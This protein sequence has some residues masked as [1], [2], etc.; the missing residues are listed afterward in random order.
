MNAK[1]GGAYPIEGFDWLMG[2]DP[3]FETARRKLAGIVWDSKRGALPLRYREIVA[4][5]VL[6]FMAYPTVD[7]HIRRA[8]AAGAKFRE[9]VEALQLVC[10]PAAIPACTTRC[11]I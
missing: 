2:L 11:R 8:L 5:V 7:A 4:S 9:V 3:E 6:A 10:I 1:P